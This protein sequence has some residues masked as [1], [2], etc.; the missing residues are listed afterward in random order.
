M[1]LLIF[2]F[3]I[4]GTNIFHN[5]MFKEHYNE[6]TNFRSFDNSLLLLLRCVTGEGWNL[7]MTDL[8]LDMSHTGEECIEN[9]T[10]EDWKQDGV[11]GCGSYISYAFFFTFVVLSQMVFINLFIA[12]VLQAY[13]TSYEENSSLITVE[14]YSNLTKLWADYDPKAEGLI[15]PQDVAFLVFELVE[16]LGKS[17]HYKDIIKQIVENNEN[18]ENNKSV[19]QKD[20]RYIIKIERNMILPV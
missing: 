12:F 1:L 8:T 2:I 18:E 14:D 16:P 19:L 13:L 6:Y 10:F 3:S 4:L 7:I 9:Q 17:E 5:V 15:D 11:K 20:Q